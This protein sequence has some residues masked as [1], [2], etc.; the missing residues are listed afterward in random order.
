MVSRVAP[1]FR[2][3]S[4]AQASRALPVPLRSALGSTNSFSKSASS[5]TTFSCATPIGFP[6]CSANR[7]G[8]QLQVARFKRQLAATRFHELLIVAPDGFR[9]ETQI[10][11]AG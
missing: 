2:A 1:S 10:G 9:P 6:P 7:D 5:L 11:K 8:R 4:V 3:T